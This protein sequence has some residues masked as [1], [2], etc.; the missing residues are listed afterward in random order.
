KQRARAY[1]NMAISLQ[2]QGKHFSAA[3]AI[4]L[5][6][7]DKFP[8]VNETM[9]RRFFDKVQDEEYA[10]ILHFDDKLPRL[11]RRRQETKLTEVSL[12]A[13]EEAIT[14]VLA[15]PQG[16]Y[17]VAVPAAA[18][19]YYVVSSGDKPAVTKVSGPGKY[20]GVSL[21]GGHLYFLLEGPARIV[22]LDV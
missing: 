9:L 19:N 6:Y 1:R 5:A 18:E 17:V 20:A 8:D 22:R 13:P 7:K 15:D 2:G 10:A 14:E 4:S 16:R 3:V 21:A 11:D 12:A